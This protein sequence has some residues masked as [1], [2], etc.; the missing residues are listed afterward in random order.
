MPTIN[1]CSTEIISFFEKTATIH[2]ALPL[3]FFSSE[4]KKGEE[5]MAILIV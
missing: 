4:K 2:L 1:S 3:L 5:V